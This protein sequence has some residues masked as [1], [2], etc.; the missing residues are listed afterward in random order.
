MEPHARR[1]DGTTPL[2]HAAMTGDLDSVRRLL[3]LGAD[4]NNANT[5][6]RWTV[7]MVAVA[8]DRADV[9]AELLAQ[10]GIE[11]GARDDLGA[12]ALH[13]AAQRG[14]ERAAALLAEH[15][16]TDPNAKDDL[17]RT[18]LSIAAFEGHAAIVERL[19]ADRQTDP[20]LVDTDRQT[21]LHW[22]ALAGRLQVVRALLA[23]ERTNPGIRNR[24]DGRT[25]QELAAGA[26]HAE[27]ADLLERRMRDDPGSDELAPGDS[28]GEPAE[29]EPIFYAERPVLESPGLRERRKPGSGGNHGMRP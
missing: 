1:E 28:P 21:A 19:L 3:S 6:N 22:A 24:P 17:G 25:A 16:G 12:T 9:I 2:Y 26:G 23:D 7:L 14:Y 20:N 11:V 8:E 4:V 27:S 5:D 29:Q 15:P 10:L 18:A 13:L